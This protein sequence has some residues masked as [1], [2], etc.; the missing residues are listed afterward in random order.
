VSRRRLI[1]ACGAIPAIVAAVL[2]LW[3][4]AFINPL[5]NAVYDALLRQTGARPPDSRIVIVDVDERS[6]ATIGQWPWRRDRIGRL[7]ARLRDMGAA[8]IALDIIFAE[9]DRYEG[10]VNAEDTAAAG[11]QATPDALLAESLGQGRVVLGYG[12]TFEENAATSNA[13]ILHP[14]SVAMLDSQDNSEDAPFFQATGA[15]CN[16]PVLSRAAGSSGFLNAAPDSDGI[17]R[18]IPVLIQLNGGI[19]PSLALSAVAALTD[20]NNVAMRVTNVNAAS[21]VLDSHIVPLDGKGNLLI[22][23]RGK[24]RTFPYVSAVDVLN[25]RLPDGTLRDKLVFVGTTALGTREVVATPLDTL[26]TG[27]EVQATAADNLLQKDFVRRP[28]LGTSYEAIAAL[29]LGLIVA[30]L[31]ALTGLLSGATVAAAGL[32]TLW[33]GSWWE[34]STQGVFISPLFVTVAAVGGL[35]AMT[36]AKFLVER[37]RAEVAIGRIEIADQRAATAGEEKVTA[38]RLMVQT[39]LSLTETRDLETGRHSRRTQQYAK[40]LA[41]ELSK[42]PSYRGFLSPERIEL[43]SSLAPLHDIGKV[44]VP[45]AVLNKPGALTPAELEEMRRHPIYGRDV[46]LRAEREA[47]VK[48]DAILSMAKEIVYT[49]HEWW[50]G[51]GY[52]EGLKGPAIPI[53]GRVMAM[54]DVYDAC[55]TRTLYRPAMSHDETV[56]FI[57]SA[58]G[59]H[60]DPAVVDAFVVVAPLLRIVSQE[61]EGLR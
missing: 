14:V 45:D 47:G 10:V 35:G 37:E 29:T 43:L 60:F 58:K 48:D 21:L 33:I 52:P 32:A 54:V 34:V 61:S 23:Y 59:S 5:D 20:V 50:D 16:L 24:K 2:A 38:Q 51:S 28:H 1:F 12:M 55:S 46:I 15:I 39:L 8:T 3:R 36:L 19:Y 27:V 42:N 57:V 26:F 7:I 56:K 4:P 22:R 18:R 31:V 17:L 11:R 6:L 53:P 25:G 9:P 30:L 49:H 13:C 44:G 40:L 41:A